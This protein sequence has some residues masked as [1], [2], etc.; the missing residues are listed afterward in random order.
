MPMPSI[1]FSIFPSESCRSKILKKAAVGRLSPKSRNFLKS[2]SSR[3]VILKG[4]EGILMKVTL[5]M[6]SWRKKSC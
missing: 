2:L 3:H 4:L 5:V 6:I 1:L